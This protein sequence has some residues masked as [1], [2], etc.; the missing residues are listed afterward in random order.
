MTGK[1]AGLSNEG[2][3]TKIRVIEEALDRYA[4]EM[5]DPLEILR[6]VGG[7]DIARTDG[8]LFRRCG[9]SDSRAH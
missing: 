4:K 8:C 5:T 6:H 3:K 9:L 1:G 2:L 7:Y